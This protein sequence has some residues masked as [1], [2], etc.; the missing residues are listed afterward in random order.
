LHRNNPADGG[1]ILSFVA[2]D[3]NKAIGDEE[4]VEKVMEVLLDLKSMM[5]KMK[6]SS[7]D[8]ISETVSLASS[9]CVNVN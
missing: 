6:L 3:W 8:K 4:E 2:F 7:A 1:D 9:G 5:N